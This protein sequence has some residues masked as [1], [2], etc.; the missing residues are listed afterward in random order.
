MGGALARSRPHGQTG[1][2]QPS[3]RI[4]F[5]V[6]L[7]PRA[8]LVAR[9]HREGLRRGEVPERSGGSSGALP[10]LRAGTAVRASRRRLRRRHRDRRDAC[11]RI[12]R[13]ADPGIARLPVVH[14]C[15]LPR[16]AGA[17]STGAHNSGSRVRSARG[18]AARPLGARSADP[19]S[20]DRGGFRVRR[21]RARAAADRLVDPA[22]ADR[23]GNVDRARPRLVR[24]VRLT[25]L[26]VVAD[27]YRLPPPDDHLRPLGDRRVHDRRRDPARACRACL[28]TRGAL[29]N[30]RR[31]DPARRVHRGR[32]VLRR[33]HRGQ[34]VVHLDDLRDPRR[35]AESHLRQPRRLHRRGALV[36]A[37]AVPDRPV[38]ARDGRDRLPDRDDALPRLRAPLLGRASASRS[39]SG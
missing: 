10:R 15:A 2:A 24:V 1:A 16:R 8:G 29:P 26:H 11:S 35:G 37:G 18:R 32:R 36:H 38:G 9:R 4:P 21:L 28:G 22:R 14:A 17:R 7:L 3:R 5:P 27:R 19:R 31:D 39:S 25:P 20:G 30:E 34:G 13:H 12:R 6:H 23:G 33:V